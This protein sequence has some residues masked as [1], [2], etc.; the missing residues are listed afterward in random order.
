M[1]PINAAQR[2]AVILRFSLCYFVMIL[3]FVFLLYFSLIEIPKKQSELTAI[4]NEQVEKLIHHT[5]DADTLVIQIQK[6][7]DVKAQALAPLFKWT[8]DLKNAYQQPFYTSIITSYVDLFNEIIKSKADDTTLMVMK[9]KMTTLQKENL[10]L[11][12]QQDDLNSELT[13]AK[14]RKD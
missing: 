9:T 8:G 11:M 13:L 12:Q 10:I 6:A 1:K 5:N 14:A 3:L 4:T 2:N 7:A